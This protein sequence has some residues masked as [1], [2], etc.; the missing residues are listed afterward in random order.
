MRITADVAS[1]RDDIHGR[2]SL[3]PA[4]ADADI[5]V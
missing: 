4:A 3:S 2:V 5:F 1:T